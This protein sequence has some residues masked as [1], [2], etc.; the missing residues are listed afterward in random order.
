[1]GVRLRVRKMCTKNSHWYNESALNKLRILCKNACCKCKRLT[2]HLKI[3][4]AH[5]CLKL[6]L[7]HFTKFVFYVNLQYTI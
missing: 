1:M 2:N 4:Y 3:V 5:I 7:S 6:N